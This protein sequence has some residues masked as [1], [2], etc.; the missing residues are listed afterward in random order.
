[1]DIPKLSSDPLIKKWFSGKRLSEETIKLICKQWGIIQ[2][3]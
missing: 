1:M 2:N 3:L